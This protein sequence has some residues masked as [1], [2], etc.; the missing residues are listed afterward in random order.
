MILYNVT[1]KIDN[2][3]H[4]EWLEYMQETHI[5]EVM[6]TGC[7][8]EN[9][10]SRMVIPADPEKDGVTYSVQYLCGN[11]AIL[12]QYQA[13]FA[14]TLQQDHK[15]RYDGK[16]VAFRSVMEIVSSITRQEISH[17]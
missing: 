17:N 14:P 10:L 6:Q 12:Q 9:R 4:D 8:L 16:F 7:F 15:Q 3:V 11:M 5:P 13:R 2:E 1:V